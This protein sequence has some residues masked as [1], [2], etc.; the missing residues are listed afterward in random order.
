MISVRVATRMFQS[1]SVLIA[2]VTCSIEF[3][4]DHIRYQVIRNHMFRGEHMLCLLSHIV[5][6]VCPDSRKPDIITKVPPPLAKIFPGTG[7][8]LA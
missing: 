4:S 3:A 2:A 6:I 1:A 5:Y 7:R 8:S